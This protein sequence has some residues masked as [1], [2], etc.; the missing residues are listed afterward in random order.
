MSGIHGAGVEY[1]QEVIDLGQGD[2]LLNP[3][4]SKN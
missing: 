2:T 4:D 1:G 3:N